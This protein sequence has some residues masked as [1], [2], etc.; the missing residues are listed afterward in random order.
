M[1]Y[2]PF[3]LSDATAAEMQFYFWINSE[4]YIEGLCWGVTT[5]EGIFPVEN[6][7]CVSGNSNGW[8]NDLVDFSNHEGVS[9][10][11]EPQVWITF[12][13]FSD[14]SISFSEGAFVDDVL[15]RKCT[16]ASC[17]ST[18]SSIDNPSE[19]NLVIIERPSLRA[20]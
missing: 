10:L 16:T 4:I 15:I 8:L 3:D 18:P 9:Y 5:T 19:G 11:G 7:S 2:G 1:D 20:R 6:Y 12:E 14:E 17:S 13:F